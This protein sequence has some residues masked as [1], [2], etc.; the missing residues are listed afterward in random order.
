MEIGIPVKIW[1]TRESKIYRVSIFIKWIK[2][3]I[4][5]DSWIMIS[6]Y[7]NDD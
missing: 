4:I 7:H 5:E 3:Q 6:N 1:E 2:I